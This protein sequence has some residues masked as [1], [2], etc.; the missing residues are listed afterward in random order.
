MT[1]INNVKVNNMENAKGNIVANQFIVRA[2]DGTYFQS[3]S[4]VI[5]FRSNNDGKV[6]LDSDYWNYS[7]T[8]GKYRN[9]FLGEDIVA[10]RKKVASGEYV[11]TNLN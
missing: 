4:S 10:T 3:Y 9:I 1:Y 7:I 8:T 2:N 5:A 11:L 6:Y